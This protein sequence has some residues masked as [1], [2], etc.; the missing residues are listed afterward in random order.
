MGALS[1]VGVTAL[2]RGGYDASP[3]G[4]SIFNL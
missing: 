1:E 4:P 2:C 3:S